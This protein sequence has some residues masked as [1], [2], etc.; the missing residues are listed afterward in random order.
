MGE[1]PRR[2][3]RFYRNSETV[4]AQQALEQFKATN[5]R[6]PTPQEWDEI[7]QNLFEQLQRSPEP[8]GTFKR[9][10]NAQSS[11]GKSSGKV[12][13]PSPS[14]SRREKYQMEREQAKAPSKEE[15]PRQK[16]QRLREE[17]KKKKNPLQ[18]ET[19]SDEVSLSDEEEKPLDLKGIL[20]K[21]AESGD[22][23]AEEPS[24]EELGGELPEDLTEESAEEEG[25]GKEE[26]GENSCKNCGTKV[27]HK[28][29]CPNCGNELCEHCALKA[30]VEG[31]LVKL[32]CP[33]CGK[34]FS[35]KR[36][37]A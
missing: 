1:L 24:L 19:D 8:R 22:E 23:S 16:M 10:K 30:K 14:L 25:E 31:A 2:L 13:A 28:I 26:T 5:K 20:G 15:S 17:A 29:V 21:E 35:Q 11:A 33:G 3:K 37:K 7:A 36:F 34:E 12:S 18:E 4:Q 32:T 9:P 6:Y 27:E